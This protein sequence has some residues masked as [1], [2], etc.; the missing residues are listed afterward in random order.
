[1]VRRRDN[2]HDE[3]AYARRTITDYNKDSN[4]GATTRTIAMVTG[5]NEDEGRR[6][7]V[8]GCYD[9]SGTTKVNAT[10]GIR[11]I[12]DADYNTDRDDSRN[13][14]DDERSRV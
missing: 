6:N 14:D 2:S 4:R 11:N 9:D 3:S 5:N 12:E 1:M 10:K 7:D 13:K 8:K